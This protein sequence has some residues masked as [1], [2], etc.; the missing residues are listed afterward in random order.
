MLVPT[1]KENKWLANSCAGFLASI[2]DTSKKE[3]AKLEEVLVVNEF[4]DVFPE[5]FPGLPRDREVTFEIELLPG[6]AP[7]SKAPYRKAPAELKK[8]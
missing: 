1:L 5:D 2:A 3:K 6:I 8:L 4:V 7:I